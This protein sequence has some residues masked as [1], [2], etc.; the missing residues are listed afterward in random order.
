VSLKHQVNE[1]LA[2]FYM[3]ARA[4]AAEARAMT[5]SQR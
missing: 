3:L 2:E 1:D 5:C 4:K